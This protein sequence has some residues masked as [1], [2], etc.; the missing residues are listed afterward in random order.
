[1]TKGESMAERLR[2]VLLSGYWIANTNIKD[3]I[4]SIT[5]Q[6]AIQK[7]GNLNSIADLTFHINYY[8]GGLNQVFGGGELE[9]RDQYSFDTP[10]INA[11]SDWQKLITDFLSNAE[12][13]IGYVEKMSDSKLD[14]IFVKE[15][16][17]TYQRNIEG[18]IEHSYYHL[19][20]ISLIKKTL[21]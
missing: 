21:N 6:Q 15:K 16:Y 11:L 1:M 7:V 18:I 20:Q 9:I 3:Q 10:R 17:G 19:G 8:V 13:F 5:W 14:E 12:K 4:E 2:E